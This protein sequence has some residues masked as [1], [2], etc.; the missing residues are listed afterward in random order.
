MTNLLEICDL[1]VSAGKTIILDIPSLTVKKGEVL[2]ILGPNGAGKSTLLQVAAGL[3]KEYISKVHF[4]E[5]RNLSDLQYRRRVSTVFQSPLLLSD[6]VEN[7][8][9][10]GLRFRGVPH[11]ELTRRVNHWMERLN[12]AHLARRR[13]D[14]LSGGEA[15]RVSLARAFCLETDLI[16]MDEPFSALDSPTRQGLLDDLRSILQEVRQTCLFVT[17]D[18]EE[19]L[20][21]ADRVAVLFNGKMHQLDATQQVFL[22]PSTPETASFVGV[23]TIIPGKVISNLNDLLQ[24]DVDNETLEAAGEL[25]IGSDVYLCLRPEDVTLYLPENLPGNSSARNQLHCQVTHLSHQGHFIRVH[26]DA[27]FPL[28]ALVTRPSAQEM[29]IQ[30]G[31][32][33]LAVFKSSAIHLIPCINR[34]TM[35]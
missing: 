10:S 30:P 31:S 14:K 28:T 1:K 29:G 4:S 18:L 27:G 19:A 12:I 2:V 9:A 3:K 35:E 8:I 15:Q 34:P 23:E 33:M 32:K 25:S 11:I 17:H 22:H 16:C 21:I 7:N 20:A 26:L 5:T 13:A 24:V 6:T